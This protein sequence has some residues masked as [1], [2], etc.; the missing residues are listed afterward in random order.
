MVFI[1]HTIL[2]LVFS[3]FYSQEH[4][5]YIIGM[6]LDSALDNKAFPGF[7]KAMSAKKYVGKV[8]VYANQD[9]NISLNCPYASF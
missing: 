2:N 5:H 3:Y 1:Q 9:Q 8:R 4:C 6:E 7:K